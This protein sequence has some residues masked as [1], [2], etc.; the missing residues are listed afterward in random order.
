MVAKKGRVKKSLKKF[1]TQENEGNGTRKR[2]T[3]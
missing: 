1:T 3:K 2:E